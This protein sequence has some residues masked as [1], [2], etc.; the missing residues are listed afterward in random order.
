MTNEI[1]TELNL[2]API[3]G[4]N[5]RI[6][7]RLTL[8]SELKQGFQIYTPTSSVLQYLKATSVQDIAVNLPCLQVQ[9]AKL[10]EF[11]GDIGPKV[12]CDFAN[13]K[14]TS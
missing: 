14:L 3:L 11:V 6:S 13:D 4:T 8:A 7:D 10:D 9:K 5:Q 1:Q 2:V 12:L